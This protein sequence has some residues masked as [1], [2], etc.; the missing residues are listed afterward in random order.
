MSRVLFGDNETRLS[1]SGTGQARI[2]VYECGS[3]T[4]TRSEIISCGP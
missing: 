2:D 1:F 3:P 4:P